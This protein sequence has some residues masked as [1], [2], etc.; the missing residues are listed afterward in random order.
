MKEKEVL[1][2]IDEIGEKLV[3]CEDLSKEDEEFLEQV[4]IDYNL[5]EAFIQNKKIYV[6]ILSF[7]SDLTKV[8]S[9]ALVMTSLSEVVANIV[10]IDMEEVDKPTLLHSVRTFL[11]PEYRLDFVLVENKKE[12]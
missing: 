6:E 7:F 11:S 5:P 10:K 3:R 2:K 4:T 1:K 12:E 8:Y 9:V